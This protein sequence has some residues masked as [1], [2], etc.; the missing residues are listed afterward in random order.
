MASKKKNCTSRYI[1]LFS[2]CS[3]ARVMSYF[4]T[5][6]SIPGGFYPQSCAKGWYTTV[7]CKYKENWGWQLVWQMTRWTLTAQSNAFVRVY[8]AC[9]QWVCRNKKCDLT[10]KSLH[11]TR[12]PLCMWLMLPK[13][14]FV[15]ARVASAFTKPVLLY[16]ACTQLGQMTLSAK[17]EL[18]PHL[19]YFHLCR[20]LW[21]RIEK[22]LLVGQAKCEYWI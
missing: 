14:T 15:F 13:N 12:L 7:S 17:C 1:Q 5:R 3:L 22:K 6:F 10:R 4:W 11:L 9:K 16:S 19:P 21:V 20:E 2:K 18:W 8:V